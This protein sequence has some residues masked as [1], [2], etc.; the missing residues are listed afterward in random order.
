MRTEADFAIIGGGIVG[1][2]VA[3]GLLKQGCSVICIDGSDTDF[4]ASRG[5]FGLVWVQ[6]KGIRA[7][8]YAAW[9]QNAARIYPDFVSELSQETGVQINYN[10]AGGYEYFTDPQTLSQR[11]DEYKQLKKALNDDYPYEFLSSSQIRAAEPMIGGETIGASF[12]PYDGHL[13]PLQLL[14]ALASYCQ[15]KGLSHYLGEEL[16]IADKKE[17]VFRLV[18]K[19]GLTI[20][21]NKVVISAGLGA[22]KIGPLF[23]FL[24]LVS[25]QRGQILVTEKISPILNRP[26]VT[27]RQVD[28]GAIQIGDSQEQAGFNDNETQAQMSRI[29]RNAIKVMPKLAQLRLVRAWG[30]LRVMSPDG[31]P[32]YHQ[33]HTMPGAFLITCH[34]GITL[35]AT[36]S[37]N[38]SLWLTGHKNAPELSR[39]SEDRFHA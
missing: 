38:L 31:L 9:T 33:S 24:G 34:S 23:G 39:F 1:L 7:P 13:N 8:F 36:H 30:S 29:A 27:I 35:A 3:H 37:T 19:K 2:S 12:Y 15:K 14:K 11:M 4:R 10:Q 18:T 26:S 25:P 21:A 20:S 22:K 17:G 5:N 32:I 6:G 16:K 28:E